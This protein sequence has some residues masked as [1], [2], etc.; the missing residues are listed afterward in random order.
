MS[1]KFY[2]LK[3]PFGCFSNFSRHPILLKGILWATNEHY[4]QAHKQ[5]G[6]ERYLQI[7]YAASP[8][9]AADM[10]RDR[11]Y[12]LR[13]DWEQVKDSIM[14][15]AVVAKVQQHPEVLKKLMETGDE[16]IIE[17]SPIDYYWG[18]GADG[19]GKNVLGK[20]LMEVREELKTERMDL[21][22]G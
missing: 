12:P 2:K 7:A 11:T 4:F 22:H 19:T 15:E 21:F 18:C 3:D 17:D 20:I 5:I 6:T 8:R 13:S 9:I 16:E 1:I 10:G 14:K